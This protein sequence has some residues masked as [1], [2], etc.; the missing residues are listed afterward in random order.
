MS[1]SPAVAIPLT[2]LAAFVAF[3][4]AVLIDAM[5]FGTTI[6]GICG[7]NVGWDPVSLWNQSYRGK[8]FLVTVVAIPFLL[9]IA[10]FALTIHRLHRH[11]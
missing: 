11:P 1:R 7:G 4:A 9:P 10:S 6:P 3:I 2:V 8:A 5:L